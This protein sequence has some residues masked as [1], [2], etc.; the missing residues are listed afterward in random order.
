MRSKLLAA[1]LVGS[2]SAQM[3]FESAQVAGMVDENFLDEISGMFSMRNPDNAGKIITCH[4][5]DA[6]YMFVL[7]TDGSYHSRIDLA[8]D[9]WRDAEEITGY[10]KNGTNYIVLCE[11][12]D[13]PANRDKKY[14]FRFEEPS[15]DSSTVVVEDWDKIA[16]RLPASPVL[17]KGQNRG[18]FEGAFIDVTDNKMYFFSK[19]M[20][21]NYIYSLPIQDEYIGTQTLTFEGLMHANVAE[22]T[23]GVISPA[24][25]VGAALSRDGNTALIKTYNM[26]FQFNR[27]DGRDWVD[28]LRNEPP[29]IVSSY[30]GRGSAPAREPQGESIC[31]DVNDSG[32]CTVSEFRGND[33]VALFYYPKEVELPPFDWSY[34]KTEVNKH[35]FTVTNG[36][37]IILQSST[38]LVN[39]SVVDSP[40]EVIDNGNGTSTYIYTREDK[41]R[42]FFRY[43]IQ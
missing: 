9:N 29:T 18:D 22:E 17:E 33:E 37:D 35:H 43:G 34:S 21:V 28:I 2:C 27:T 4:D 24:N 30:V 3:Q 40:F 11:F 6:E 7:N 42:E 41:D 12:G 15:L 39:W 32:F 10:T 31:F 8:L 26:V 20:P 5:S 25:C 19:R 23:G 38:D 36:Y 14:L 1:A 16:Y 13:N